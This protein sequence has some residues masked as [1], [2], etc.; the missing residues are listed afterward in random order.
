VT[1]RDVPADS[2]VL[3]L[4]FPDPVGAV[5]VSPDGRRLAVLYGGIGAAGR[6]AVRELPSGRPLYA[7]TVRC[8]AGQDLEFSRDGRTLLAAGCLDGGEI[9]TVWDAGSGAPLFS[10]PAIWAAFTPDSRTLAAGTADGRV[11]LSDAR[12]GRQ[13]GAAMQ[14]ARGAVAQIAI[15][16]G[17]RLLAVTGDDTTLWDIASRQRVGDHFPDEPG[18]VQPI[19]FEP[20]GRLLFDPTHAE[21]PLD[22]PTLQ[23]FACRA[24][25]RD[26]TRAEWTSLLPDRPYRR[27][28][29]AP[30]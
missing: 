13:R 29:P 19:A 30:K 9:A 22:L 8:G 23:R 3:R 16:P 20:N 12:T 15:S 24:A 26:L 17:G 1:I 4:R 27:V 25:G 18:F 11:V 21:W 7:H 28:C 6:L 10:T 2:V 14:T 5:A